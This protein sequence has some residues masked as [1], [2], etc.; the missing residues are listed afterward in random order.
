MLNSEYPPLGGGQGNANKYLYEEF[1][2]YSNLEIDIIT[3]SV[4]D[5][6]V[7]ISTLGKIYYLDI[8]KKNT[9]LHWQSA[10]ELIVYSMKSLRLALKLYRNRK[11][12]FIVAWSGVP[13]GLLAYILGLIKNVPYITLLR[14]A[15]VPFFEKK[16]QYLDKFIFYWLS[17]IIWK[18][19]KF[20]IINSSRLG[21]LALQL[22]P[23]QHFYLIPNGI[24]SKKFS[25]KDYEL[26]DKLRILSVGRLTERKGFT[27]LIEALRDINGISLTIIGDGPLLATLKYQSKGLDVTFLGNVAHEQLIT[28]YRNSDVFVLPSLNE[29]MSNTVLEAMACGLPLIL[30]DVGGSLELVNGNGFIVPTNNSEAIKEKITEFLKDRSLISTMGI[31]SR[32]LAENMSWSKVAQ[33]YFEIF[34]KV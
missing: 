32:Q 25:G 16:W 1:K 24:D 30:T 12:D 10:K 33:N 5:N 7:E 14:G 11:Y 22:S 27:Y 8:G 4:N 3:A 2:N 19:S 18:N 13:S 6:K 31:T 29:G 9:N 20:V 34:E 15:D 28:I 17:P 23:K 26:H 21:K